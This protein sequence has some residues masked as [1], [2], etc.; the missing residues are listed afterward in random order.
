MRSYFVWQTAGKVNNFWYFAG[1]VTT[2]KKHRRLT[3]LFN[4][5]QLNKTDIHNT[6]MT[7]VGIPA[8]LLVRLVRS[9][10]PLPSVMVHEHWSSDWQSFWPTAP[11]AHT[12]THSSRITSV[13]LILVVRLK[14]QLYVSSWYCLLRVPTLHLYLLQEAPI[15]LRKKNSNNWVSKQSITACRSYTAYIP[16][17]HKIVPIKISFFIFHTLIFIIEVNVCSPPWQYNCTI[18]IQ[19][20]YRYTV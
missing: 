8:L 5:V 19:F 15:Y 6:V 13:R 10:L 14:L 9:T 3:T 18:I 12:A 11:P 16:F 1:A 2:Q 17:I 4:T 7:Y 20:R